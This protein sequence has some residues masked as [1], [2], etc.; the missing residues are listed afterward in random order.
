MITITMRVGTLF[1][2][3]KTPLH[4][5][6]RIFSL[7]WVQLPSSLEQ[8][9]HPFFAPLF[10]EVYHSPTNGRNRGRFTCDRFFKQAFFRWPSWGGR[11]V[12]TQVVQVRSFF[13]WDSVFEVLTPAFI[14]RGWI[15]SLT[16]G[17]VIGIVGCYAGMK[18]GFGTAGV[19]EA[20]ALRGS[21][22]HHHPCP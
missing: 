8:L 10:Q 6:Y 12:A 14:W 21:L 3:I 7:N 20:T 19:R 1:Y 15:K 13:Y 11:L 4:S 22:C 16:F 18:T 9:S 5:L 17:F 2:W